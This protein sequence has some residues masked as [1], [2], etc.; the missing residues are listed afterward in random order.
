MGAAK[1]YED[2][3]ER[4]EVQMLS[5][6]LGQDRDGAVQQ[7]LMLDDLE[8]KPSETRLGWFGRAQSRDSQYIIWGWAA[9]EEAL[10]GE[11]RGE[12][13]WERTWGY[14]DGNVSLLF[15][16]LAGVI[17]G[18]NWRIKCSLHYIG[19]TQFRSDSSMGKI[20]HVRWNVLQVQTCCLYSGTSSQKTKKKSPEKDVCCKTSDF[21][22]HTRQTQPFCFGI[23]R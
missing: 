1:M 19:K 3:G 9:R 12:L 13:A 16:V 14:R 11:Q 4:Q 5:S 7:M 23:L 20:F 18:R 17:N 21:I 10:G 22:S 15:V 8:V 2:W 6:S